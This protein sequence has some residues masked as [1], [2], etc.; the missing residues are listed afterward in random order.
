MTSSLPL[1][2]S[3]TVEFKSDAKRLSDDELVLA[4]VCLANTEGGELYL[5]VEDDGTVTGLHP[6][7]QALEPLPA[8]IGN[9][10][11]PP[12][13][14]SVDRVV[15]GDKIVARISVPKMRALVATSKG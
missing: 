9:F 2:E 14:V 8:V 15:I 13:P 1:K 10:T 12:V 4:V 11:S 5:G 3:L 7:H 6:A